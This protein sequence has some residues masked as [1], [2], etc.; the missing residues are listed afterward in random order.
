M[1]GEAERIALAECRLWHS[2]HFAF[3]ISQ[4]IS[5]ASRNHEASISLVVDGR[6]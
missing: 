1:S 3:R 2:L 6:G 4:R 5:G